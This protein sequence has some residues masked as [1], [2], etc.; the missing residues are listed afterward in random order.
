MLAFTLWR[1]PLMT[2]KIGITLCAVA[3]VLTFSRVGIAAS[4]LAALIIVLFR[5]APHYR[6]LTGIATGALFAAGLLLS[7][8]VFAGVLHGAATAIF[9]S[10]G[11]QEFN[12]GLGSR[13]DLWHGA[14][15]LWRAHPLFGVGPGNY[16]YA[17]GRFFPGVRTHANSMYFQVLAEQGAAGFIALLTMIA[18]TLGVFVR[19]L[20]HPL[21]L[22]ACVAVIAINFH[23]IAD[24]IWLYPKVGVMLWAL[25][26]VAAAEVDLANRKNGLPQLVG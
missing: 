9:G 21:A 2:E 8:G 13:T 12:G 25:I 15:L 11:G 10:E 16:E 1:R 3:C 6:K 17:V 23:Q 14:Y 20:R 5:Y 4:A 7:F 24:C 26:A 22:G 18:A 19:R